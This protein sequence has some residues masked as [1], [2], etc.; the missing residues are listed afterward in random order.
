M[1]QAVMLVGKK[2]SIKDVAS[3]AGV[4]VSTVS[5]VL[6]NGTYVT[7]EKRRRI[8]DAV[9]QLDFRP[10]YFAKSL[11]AGVSKIIA[12]I[13]P[14][15]NNPVYALIAQGAESVTRSQGYN[16]I[17]CNTDEDPSLELEHIVQLKSRNVDGII[18]ATARSDTHYIDELNIP[19]V[20]VM[21]STMGIN[22]VTVDNFKI[23]YSA[24]EYLIKRGHRKIFIFNGDSHISSFRVRTDGYR[25][26]MEDNGIPAQKAYEFSAPSED[27]DTLFRLSVEM[28]ENCG[29]PD[30]IF[31]VN[32]FRT[33]GVY[34]AAKKLGIRIPEDMSVMGVDDLIFNEFLHP[35]LTT[36]S[37]PFYEMGTKAAEILLSQISEQGRQSGPQSFMQI[38]M[39]TSIIERDSVADKTVAAKV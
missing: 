22:A 9:A 11:K 39:P 38:I 37:Q 30:A 35:P 28:I 12:L 27:A 19:M 17:L 31:C 15:I 13:V 26:A 5:R 21:R 2:V 18:F 6:N 34:G 4:S 36:V 23:G 8:M 24:T 7:E 14:N 16:L 1:K 3:L 20:A 33:I 25:Q 10:N 29:V 32:W